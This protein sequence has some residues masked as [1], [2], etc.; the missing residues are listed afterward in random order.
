MRKLFPMRR[1]A[2]FLTIYIIAALF[3]A[4]TGSANAQSLLR[5]SETELFFKEISTPIFQAAKLDPEAIKMFLI[6]DR[7]INAFVTGGQNIFIHSGLILAADDANQLLGVIAHETGH[8]AGGHLNRI[9]NAAGRLQRVSI[10]SMI[11]AAATI[12]AGAGDAGFAI[13]SLGSTISYGK[14]ATF[15]RVQEASADAA[16]IKYLNSSNVSALGLEQFFRKL[17]SQE[18]NAGVGLEKDLFMRSHPLT[19][20][21]LT[22]IR[23]LAQASHLYDKPVRPDW[24]R[25]FKRVRGKLYGYMRDPNET[26]ARYPHEDH[27]VEARLA[28]SYAWH[29]LSELEKA[30]IEVDALLKDK[31]KDPYFLE[32][33]G[34]IM[35]ENGKLNDAIPYLRKSVAYSNGDPLIMTSLSFALLSPEDPALAREAVGLLKRVVKLDHDNPTAWYQL[36]RGYSIMKDEA[37]ANLAVAEYFIKTDRPYD[38]HVKA[39]QAYRTLPKNSPE[40]HQAGDI[41]VEAKYM[42]EKKKER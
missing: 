17:H 26:F 28:R 21:R 42:L 5:D 24:Q 37:R 11:L 19:A 12:A 22:F 35:L 10:L 13:M 9:E 38:A 14:L 27:S 39:R 23:D 3:W 20:D 6:G 33:K 15:S 29:K 4:G 34:Q 2:Q 1:A 36:G 18:F 41:I 32:M 7:S 25:R 40:W 8:I 30:L 31:P 16:S